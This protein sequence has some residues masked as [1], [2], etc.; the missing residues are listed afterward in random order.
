MDRSWF[1][2]L[3]PSDALGGG[4]A[5]AVSAILMMCAQ[6]LCLLTS[7]LECG[8]LSLQDFPSK[9]LKWLDYGCMAVDGEVFDVG[10][11]SA[12]ALGRLWDGQLAETTGDATES[13]NGSSM[14]VLP[15]ALWYAGSDNALVAPTPVTVHRWYK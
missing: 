15:L 3:T 1:H 8:K 5:E 4:L 12:Q 7:L 6:A 14:R 10:I 13:D 11:Q 2:C 9:L